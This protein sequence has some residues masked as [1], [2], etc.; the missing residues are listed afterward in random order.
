MNKTRSDKKLSLLF[1]ALVTI[2]AITALC[3]ITP[4][5]NGNCTSAYLDPG[6]GTM[7]ISAIVGILAT[8]AL[9]IKTFWYKIGRL[10][11]KDSSKSQ[12]K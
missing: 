4:S 7:I 1:T 9:G 12:K 3:G 8:A 10:F 5:S 2:S 11:K 6:T